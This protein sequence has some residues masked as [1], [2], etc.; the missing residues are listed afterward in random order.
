MVAVISMPVAAPDNARLP[1]ESPRAAGP[2]SQRTVGVEEEFVLLDPATGAPA[3]AAPDLLRVLSGEPGVQA[4]LMRFQ[5]ETATRVCTG[6]DEVRDEL[7]RLR[8]LVAGAAKDLGYRLVAS[9]TAPLRTPG[10]AALSDRARYRDLA[11]RFPR[12]T[13]ASGTCGCHVHVGVPSRDTGVQVLARLRPWLAQL[14]ALSANSPI[15]D[16]RD[17]GWASWRYR[18]VS[19]W[20]T[21]RP[22]ALWTDAARYDA[23]VRRLIRNGAALDEASI[24]FLA[25]LSAR[26]PTVEVRVADVCLDIDTAVGLAALVRA[27]VT[28][29]LAEIRTGVPATPAPTGRITA[30]LTAAA[31]HGLH[32]TGIDPIT[33]HPLRHRHLLD[34][35]VDHA[36]PALDAAGDTGHVN[37]LLRRIDEWGTGTDQQ[38]TLWTDN[39]TPSDF[40]EALAHAT[41]AYRSA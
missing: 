13:P 4:E 33:G 20:P 38:R 32:G 30:G 39:R 28:T 31:H 23:T 9:G 8:R 11:R 22:P 34:R 25:R 16:G 5:F 29:A 26:Y 41:C 14:L 27:L 17:T 3:L 36:W 12:I 21:A 19:R 6:L 40:T 10:L 1:G 7:L 24:Y 2:A 18:L 15:V 37:R 35:L